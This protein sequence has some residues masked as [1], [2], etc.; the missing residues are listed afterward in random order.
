MQIAMRVITSDRKPYGIVII[1]V[2]MRPALDR[3]R[4][5]VRPGES[6][7]LVDAKGDYLVHPDT[8]REFGSQRGRPADWRHDM[9]YFASLLGAGKS[10]ALQP[11][12]D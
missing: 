3:V 11:D 7:Y 12:D 1:D 9:P 10:L 4:S 5:S 8:N 2:D 6:A